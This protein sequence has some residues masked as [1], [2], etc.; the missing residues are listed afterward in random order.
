MVIE[1]AM[2]NLPALLGILCAV[3]PWRETCT[4]RGAKV[5]AN[6]DVYIE[7]EGPVCGGVAELSG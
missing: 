2:T 5:S 7:R 6:K 1:H 3:D 4:G